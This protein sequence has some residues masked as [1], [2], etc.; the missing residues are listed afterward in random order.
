ML[1]K[2]AASLTA[3]KLR[4]V[5]ISLIV[6]ILAVCIAGFWYFRSQLVAYAEQVQSDN[7]IAAQSNDDIANLQNIEKQLKDETVAVTRAK[8]IVAD[9]QY[10]QYQNQIISDI[11]KYAKNSGVTITGF[12]FSDSSTAGGGASLGAGA[13]VGASPT[14]TTPIP[15]GLKSITALITIKTPATYT[16]IMKFTHAIELNLTKMQL[17]GISMT[18]STTNPNEVTVSPITIEVYTR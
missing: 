14:T 8:N 13:A 16:A 4:I 9:S 6:L 11:N 3:P 1:K 2:Q 10:Y 7:A 5:L 15:A 12:T 17:S 18:G